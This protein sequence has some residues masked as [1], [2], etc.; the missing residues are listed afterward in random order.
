MCILDVPLW[1]HD[2]VGL[3]MTIKICLSVDFRLI[4]QAFTYD[5]VYCWGVWLPSFWYPGQYLSDVDG[6]SNFFNG[7]LNSEIIGN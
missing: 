6:P 2:E 3:L 5:E 7:Q 1:L 4:N